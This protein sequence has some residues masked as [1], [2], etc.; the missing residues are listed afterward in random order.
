[1]KMQFYINHASHL[2]FE[3]ISLFSGIPF[4]DFE[5]LNTRRVDR[6]EIS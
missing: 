4:V 3:Q 2:Y 6:I 1:M 5:K